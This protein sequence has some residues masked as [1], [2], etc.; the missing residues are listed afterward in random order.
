M[1]S[2][3]R[4]LQKIPKAYNQYSNSNQEGN[5]CSYSNVYKCKL[6]DESMDLPRQYELHLLHINQVVSFNTLIRT[7]DISIFHQYIAKYMSY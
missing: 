2:E 6:D 1:L 7:K 4:Y 3:E 5:A